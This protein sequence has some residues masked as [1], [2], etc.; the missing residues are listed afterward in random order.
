MNRILVLPGDGIGPEIV[1]E[2]L[3]VLERVA[4]IGGLELEIEQGLIGGAAHDAAGHPYPEATR[5]QAR[6]ADAILLGAVGGPQY[7]SLERD[8]RPERGLLGIRSDLELFANLRPAIL[9]PQLA[10]ASTLKPEVVS[11]L[12]LLIVRELTGGIYFSQPRGIEQR[13]GQRYGYNTAGYTES[14]IERIAR[15]GFEA[16]MKRNK[17][18]CSVDKANVLEVSELWREVVERVGKEFPEVELSHMYVDNAAMQ[19]VRDPKQF[20][21]MVTSN[22]F[23]DILSDAAAML[24]GSIGM[25]PSA[26]LNSEGVGLYEPIH[27]SAPDIAGQGKANPMATV[28]S[29][30]MMLRHSLNR[31]DLAERLEAAVGRVLDQGLRTPDIHGDGMQ[32]VST[33]GMGDA[34]VAALDDA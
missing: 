4:E 17:R 5:E 16:A 30:A 13:D 23:G 19:L 32:L 28:L 6:R 22:M 9:Y 20:D 34:L 8:L 18:L 2:A 24:T 29:I 3:K 15:V 25:L 31:N 14:E 26:S 1:A 33:Q 27:G 21:V 11:G 12:D 10:S 7:E